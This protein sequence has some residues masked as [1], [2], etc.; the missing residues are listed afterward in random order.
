[1]SPAEPLPLSDPPAPAAPNVNLRVWFFVFL[2]W[3]S[4]LATAATWALHQADNGSP[5]GLVV[6]M[7]AIYAFY[8]SLCCTFFP[9]PTSWAVLLAAS[10]MIA[11]Q[12]GVEPYHAAR[13]VVVSTVGALATGMANLNEYHVFTYLLSFRRIAHVRDTR[14]Y[15]VA[16][17]WFSTNPFLVIAAF[18][19]I[20]IP[21]DVIRWLAITY[22]YPRGRFFLAYFIGRWIRYAGWCLAAMELRLTVLHII[23][24]QV[25]MVVLALAKVVPGLIRQARRNRCKED[26]AAARAGICQAAE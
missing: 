19:L 10:D 25:L 20:P 8:L 5:L 1:M 14:T 15:H 12:A 7:L 24:I 21:V 17:R 6:W 2:A 26:P 11:R 18:S 4:S 23:L 22:R 16:A 9:G 13:L 3:M